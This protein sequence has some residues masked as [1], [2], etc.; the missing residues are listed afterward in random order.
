MFAVKRFMISSAIL[1]VAGIGA[2]GLTLL[3]KAPEKKSDPD[4][5]VYVSAESVERYTGMIDIELTG[6]VVPFREINIAA[7]VSGRVIE[8]SPDFE[9]GRFVAAG[10]VMMKIDPTDYDLEI[11]R[12]TAD[13]ATSDASIGELEV[14]IEGAKNL[15]QIAKSD[16]KLQ[17][18]DY[19]RKRESNAGFSKSEL[20]QVKRTV[21]A[22]QNALTT[23]QNRVDLLEKSR[24]GIESAQKQ[25]LTQLELAKIRKART[26]ITAPADG[27]VIAENVEVGGFVQ[28]GSAIMVFEDTSKAEVRCNFRPDQLDWLWNHVIE[29]ESADSQ[30]SPYR[31]PRVPV[32][33]YQGEGPAALRWDGILDRYDGIGIDD[34]TKTVPCRV[35]VEDPIAPSPTGSRPLV[36]GMFVRLV[37]QLPTEPLQQKNKFFA[38]IPSQGVLAGDLI[39]LLRDEKLVSLPVSIVDRIEQQE[40]RNEDVVI[41]LAGQGIQIGDQV[42]TSPIGSYLPGTPVKTLEAEQNREAVDPTRAI[43]DALSND[44]SMTNMAQAADSPSPKTRTKV[45]EVNVNDSPAESAA[46]SPTPAGKSQP[47][48]SKSDAA[49]KQPIRLDPPVTRQKSEPTAGRS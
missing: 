17:L 38:K 36:R 13:L 20:D 25:K 39:W 14:E 5:A 48:A 23:L 35:V 34:Q 40:L 8:K 15:L 4:P 10:T 12:I 41:E 7:E 44:P 24:T 47:S 16:L 3:K 29:V 1:G 2:Y 28:A 33:V 19:E 42:V 32:A 49:E 26:I 46:E 18:A 30:L 37:I 9:S 31:I 27:V 21:L 11:A 6:L 43:P 22:A 45:S